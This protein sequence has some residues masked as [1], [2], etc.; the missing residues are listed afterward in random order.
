MLRYPKTSTFQKQLPVLV[1]SH[2]RIQFFVQF[3]LTLFVTTYYSNYESITDK[4]EQR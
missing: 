2:S 1:G 4:E 3:C